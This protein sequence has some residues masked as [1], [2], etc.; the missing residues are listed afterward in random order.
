[1]AD[2]KPN[3][4]PPSPDSAPAQPDPLVAEADDDL[5]L[6]LD[7]IDDEE[8][9]FGGIDLENLPPEALRGIVGGVADGLLDAIGEAENRF[10]AEL[11]VSSIFGVLGEG[12]APDSDDAQRAHAPAVLVGELSAHCERNP[13]PGTLDLL[14]LL[15]DQGPQPARAA[16]W[17]A[18]ERVRAQGVAPSAWTDQAVAPVTRAWRCGDVAGEQISLGVRFR[19]AAGHE[20]T[21]MTLIDAALGGGLKDAWFAAGAEAADL[22]ELAA[23]QM[24]DEPEGF[25]EELTE[26]QA[27]ELLRP[28]FAVEPCPAD[29]DQVED[30]DTFLYLAHSRARQMAERLGEPEVALYADTVLREATT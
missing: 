25:F 11:A 1:M 17:A 14:L 7:E 13:G 30:V 9:I 3:S 24:A 18:A 20:H 6:Y 22:P 27:L 12:L 8:D 15:A 19:D 16:A 23:A 10:D 26:Q 4:P 29:P 21:L 2:R 5:G 28:A